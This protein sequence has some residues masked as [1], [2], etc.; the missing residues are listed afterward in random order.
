MQVGIE[1]EGTSA[2]AVKQLDAPLYL[3]VRDLMA[4]WQVS[5]SVAYKTVNDEGFPPSLKFGSTL[6]FS[7]I[8]VEQWEAG[9]M[10]A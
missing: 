10:G 6:R 9:R 7:R 4:R 2:P 5:R 1:V 3:S 8:L